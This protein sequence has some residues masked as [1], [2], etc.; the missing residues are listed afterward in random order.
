MGVSKED[1]EGILTSAMKPTHLQVV[2][3]SGGCGASF[4]IEIVSEQFEGKKLLERHRMVN[5]ALAEQMKEIH[6]LSIKKAVTP[7]KWNPI[8]KVQE[9]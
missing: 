1:V 4:E 7:S 6:A 5:A 3:T 8:P 9:E 2:D